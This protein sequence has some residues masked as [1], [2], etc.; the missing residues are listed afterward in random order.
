M[1]NTTGTSYQASISSSAFDQLGLEFY[2][3]GQD[4]SGT[5]QTQLYFIYKAFTAETASAIPSIV[6]FGGT[7]KSY[8]IISIPFDLGANNN[9]ADI[10]EPELGEYDKTK[11]RLVR[12]QNGK[13]TDYKAGIS[14]IELGQ[15][16][17]FNSLKQVSITPPAGTAPKFN[18]SSSFE[19]VLSQGWNQIATPYPFNIDWNDVLEANG[20]LPGIGNYKVFNSGELNFTESNSLKPYEGGFVFTDNAVN[21]DIP[22]ILKN[23][24]GGRKSSGDLSS[25]ID[26][27]SWLVPLSIIQGDVR[28][29]EG[30]VGM[31]PQ[32]SLTKDRWDD[33]TVPRFIQY[34]ETN[35]YHPEFFWPKFTRD[36]V[37]TTE[38]YEWTLSLESNGQGSIELRWDAAA[39]AHAQSG[40]FLY[41][42]EEGRLVDMRMQ[43]SLL[44]PERSRKDIKIVFTHKGEY[45]PD[46]TMLGKAWPNPVFDQ[47]NI[48]F[49]LSGG[50]T[51]YQVEADVYDLKG[52]R[53]KSVGI[54]EYSAGVHTTLWDGK[55]ASGNEVSNGVYIVKLKVNGRY[56]P[57]FCKI[58]INRNH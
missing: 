22:V 16:Y 15:S 12:Y 25:N 32:A 19:M 45:I 10:F 5:D 31:H 40:L 55:D 4:G 18:Q 29:S 24:A 8:Q 33:V 6:R 56:L 38:E 20:N 11:W 1:S 14:K 53:L 30:G 50:Q 47:V 36:V 21:L 2:V 49:V 58:V 37:P 26:D 52:V 44:I 48:P 43:S 51:S 34:L 39:I 54:G 35:F 3:R 57:E 46:R 9:M 41:D 17:W 27:E 42:E 28:N 7:Q 23:T 13:N